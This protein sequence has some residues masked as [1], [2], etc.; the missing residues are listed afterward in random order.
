M[1][2]PMFIAVLLAGLVA[3]AAGARAAD[4]SVEGCCYGGPP[5]IA[6][7]V[8][9]DNEPGVVMNRWWLPP[10]RNRHF[11]PH[12]VEKLRS[13]ARPPDE[14]SRPRRAPRYSRYWTNPPVYLLDSS[15]LLPDRAYPMPRPRPHA[16]P[17]AAATP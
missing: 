14:P 2:A 6:P 1:R 15:P 4:L 17:P 11:Y 12:G 7:V 13:D 16:A 10:W 5:P 3:G 9:I 8:I